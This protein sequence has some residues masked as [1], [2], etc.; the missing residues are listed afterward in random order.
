MTTGIIGY[1]SARGLGTMTHDIRQQL[2]IKHQIVPVDAGWP[3]MDKWATGGEFYLEQWAVQK[4]DLE[5]WAQHFGID[6]VVS[7]ETPYGDQTFKWA[8]ELGLK[9]TLLVMWEAFNPNMPAY[10]NVD[11]YIC[12]SYRAYQEVPFDNKIFLPYPVDTNAFAYRQRRGP[13]KTFI[14]NAGSWGMNGR[15][16]TIET[17]K[18]FALAARAVPG[19]ELIVRSQTDNFE[20]DSESPPPDCVTFEVG[21]KETREELYVE[22]DVLIYPSLYDGH[23]LVTLEGM[24]AGMP[25]ITTDATPMNEYWRPN[26][27]PLL[28]KVAEERKPDG[29]VNPHCFSQI[30]S[31]EDLARKIVWCAQNDME[32]I[33]KRNREIAETEHSW[34]AL[35]ERWKKALGCL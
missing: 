25:V 20:L 22:G 16:G 19:I 29:L 8:K 13:A 35:R 26:S 31:I 27:Y 3:Y 24:A 9:T 17:I 7:I 15:K 34:N 33:S 5:L 18:A 11:L 30:V 21:S 4:E 14:H 28:V 1:L 10:R 12:P 6:T 23:A 32:D 2:G